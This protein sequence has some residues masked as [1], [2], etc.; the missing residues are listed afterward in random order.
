MAF[1]LKSGNTTNFKQMGATEAIKQVKVSTS[2]YP[3]QRK[4]KMDT[5]KEIYKA[6]LRGDY[7]DLTGDKLK[8]ASYDDHPEELIKGH[9]I[10]ESP[11]KQKAEHMSLPQFEYDLSDMTV[12]DKR[13]QE[14]IDKEK[15]EIK[16]EEE[17]KR[18]DKERIDQQ[19]K[20]T[21]VETE[22]DVKKRKMDMIEYAPRKK[23]PAKQLTQ[24]LLKK[25]KGLGPREIQGEDDQ[26]REAHI[27]RKEMG[28]YKD[29]SK[30]WYKI[31]GQNVSK[32]AYKKY[33]NKPGSDEP[34]K[35]TND[36]DVYGRKANNHGRGPKTKK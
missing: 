11:A 13:S 3:N 34:G 8:K 10:P 4:S 36:P 32:E 28:V 35:Q 24:V 22:E 5:E 29:P 31:N 7:Q 2:K 17:A 9:S 25:R 18:K 14:V 20:G 26:S 6:K 16:K 1:K 23:S 19:I 12:V 21:Y 27:T 15:E 30:Y 33:E